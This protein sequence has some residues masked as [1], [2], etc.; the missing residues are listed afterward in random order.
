MERWRLPRDV[1][2]H[3][4]GSASTELPECCRRLRLRLPHAI[5]VQPRNTKSALA[6]DDHERHTTAP[7]LCSNLSTSIHSYWRRR[8]GTPRAK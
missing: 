6:N 5:K 7:S 1:V 3:V 8:N 4:L 2:W